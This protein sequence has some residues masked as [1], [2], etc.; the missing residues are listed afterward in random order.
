[1]LELDKF[2]TATP[3]ELEGL[4]W[5]EITSKL[6]LLSFNI[7]GNKSIELIASFAQLTES[8]TVLIVGCGAGGSAI[9]LAEVTKATVHG[10]DIS[11]ESIRIAN[12]MASK[13]SAR[14]KL[15]FRI[16]DATALDFPPDTFDVVITEF[17]AFF[18]PPQAFGGF[19]AVL[20]SSGILALAELVKDPG[21]SP[22]ADA[23]ILAAEGIYSEVLG[24]KFHIPIVTEYIDWV[25]QVGFGQVRVEEQ[26]P[27][28]GIRSR[29]RA[30]GGWK[31]LFKIS[32]VMLRLM[33]G[34]PV[35]KKKF[36]QIGRVKRVLYQRRSTAKYISQVIL[37]GRK[38]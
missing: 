6:G 26:V 2:L 30:I 33:R 32:K 23:K 22:K 38:P 1:M 17:M 27:K 12:E 8:S 35:L 36:M 5:F 29:V 19:L 15:Q 11:P 25:T 7:S 20:K 28:L 16:G 31:K 10:I 37:V 34:S 24:Y 9:H 3:K 14:D 4:S 13:S 21:V 18:L